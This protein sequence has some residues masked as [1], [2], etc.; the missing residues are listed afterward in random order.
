MR[1]GVRL[2][3]DTT[4]ALVV[5]AAAALWGVHVVDERAEVTDIAPGDRVEGAVAALRD[6][7]VYVTPDGRS[8]LAEDAE[9]RLEDVIAGASVPVHVVV[10]HSS[11]EAGGEPYAFRLP[12]ML[13]EELDEPGLYVVWQGPED[14]YA[15]APAGQRLDWDIPD[16]ESAGDAERRI[17]E[18]VEGLGPDPLIDEESSDY[19]GGI[20]GGIAAGA[21]IG[22]SIALGAW[23]LVGIVR[24]VTGRPFRN[25][26]PK[27]G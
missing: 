20:G 5:G 15:E 22:G 27:G 23:V 19:W 18:F 21:L 24:A 3:L 26:P 16:L 9:R 4:A 8:M 14:A 2:A 12:E 6:S 25:R 10:W 11:Q 17:T 13:A 1:Y 7:S